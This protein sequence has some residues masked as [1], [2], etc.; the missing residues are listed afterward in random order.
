MKK[1]KKH[2]LIVEGGGFKIA[3]T[4]G[5]LDTFL[6]AKY[7]P[8]DNYVAVSGGTVALSYYLSKQFRYCFNAMEY[9]AN[10]VRFTNFR[11]TLG[12]EGYMDIDFIKNVAEELVPFDFE[13]ALK[14]GKKKPIHF[15]ATNRKHG[16]PEYFSPETQKEWI[17]YSI[18]SST[19][20]FV[21]K[22]KHKIK[23]KS[24]FDGGW[25]DGMPVKWAH[26]NGSRKILVLRTMPVQERKTQSWS[27][28]IGSLIF[29]ES[30]GLKK[31]FA[32]SHE[33]F[34]EAL[35]FI[36]NPPKG[37]KVQQIGPE[38]TLQS[39]TY[40]YSLETIKQD[41]RYGVEMGM[42]FLQELGS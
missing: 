15:V 25:S 23:G 38:E 35:D 30:P 36:E 33:G 7:N 11:R 1:E 41:Y 31:A 42:R 5:V 29:S 32:S 24:Y 21:T 13:K 39:G 8:F 20:P 9:L 37:L 22:G 27:D 14:V 40:V 18:A 26:E 19:L 17:N 16:T 12:N 4:A 6:V 3:F 2:T 28:Y 10:D 34:N